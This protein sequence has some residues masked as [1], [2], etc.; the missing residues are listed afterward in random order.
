ML[1]AWSGIRPLVKDPKKT[2]TK[3]V[4]RN[5]V[6][7]V[8]DSK[9]ITITGGKFT[10][11][12]AMAKATI[13]K[14]LK[15]NKI[16]NFTYIELKFL[17]FPSLRPKCRNCQTGNLMLEG[18]HNWHED[19][20]KELM[21]LYGFDEKIAKHLVH[22]YGDKAF[23]V[24]EIAAEEGLS[25][26]KH[27]FILKFVGS[28]DEINVRLHN[29]YPHSPAEVRYAIR[30]QY[31]HSAEDVIARRLTLAILDARAAE[32]ALPAVIKVMAEERCWSDGKIEIVLCSSTR[33]LVFQR[34]ANVDTI[35]L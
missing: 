31:A 2:D 4:A 14:A 13:D 24:A 1:A 10:T 29:S 35:R 6:I 15:G 21:E 11:F 34:N 23:D 26:Q 7:A 19:L 27:C 33:K 32:K 18:A 30:Q 25:L 28:S 20:Y 12:R 17:V 9:L 5:H 22:C 3:S 8:S 16:E